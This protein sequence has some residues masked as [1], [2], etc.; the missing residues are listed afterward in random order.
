MT[1]S[2]DGPTLRVTVSGATDRGRLDAVRDRAERTAVVETG[3]TGGPDGPYAYAT[4]DGRTALYAAVTGSTLERLLDACEA[5]SLPTAEAEAVTDEYGP[6]R[7]TEGPLSVGTPRVLEGCGWH[8]PTTTPDPVAPE[9]R[10]DPEEVLGTVE[11]IGLCGRG[12]A[13][14]A[15]DEPLAESWRRIRDGDGDPVLVVNAADGDPEADA[16]RL[17]C[18]SAAGRLYDAADAVAAVVAAEDVVVL[19]PDDPL[20]VERLEAAGVWHVVAAEDE[21]RLG[22]PTMALERLE[23][24]DRIEARRRPPGPEEWGLYGRPTAVH[25]PRTLLQLAELWRNPEAFAADAA[26]PGTRLVTVGGDVAAPATVELSTDVSLS[27]ALSA[28]DSSADA[29]FAVG[30][31]FGGVTRSLDVPASAAALDAAGLGTEGIVEVLGPDRCI[32]ASVGERAAFAREENCG[33]CVPCREGSKQLHEALRAVYDGEFDAGEIRELSRVMAA[34]SLCEF[35]ETA[36]RPVRTALEDF[37]GEF[38]AHADGRCP[39]GA[40]GGMQ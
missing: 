14:A 32:V 7:P 22:E 17:L 29:R 24:N 15:A 5:G 19:A 1:D 8:A 6:P 21:F 37:E 16:D 3:P 25:T 18:A 4:V 28:V 30:G 11:E 10:A 2:A 35:G 33:R 36:A 38:R 23:G 34:T 27:T 20:V 12:R 40:C 39:A 9:A 13:D 31:R 26:D